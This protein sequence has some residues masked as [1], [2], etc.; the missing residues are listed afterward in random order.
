[1]TEMTAPRDTRR[2]DTERRIELAAVTTALELGFDNVTI[3]EICS[4]ADIARS[5]FFTHFHARDAAVLG[6]PLSLLSAEEA[7]RVFDAH[8]DNLPLGVHHLVV[9]SAT[10]R[11]TADDVITAR[12]RLVT[13]Q[14]EAYVYSTAMLTDS[15]TDIMTLLEG[16]LIAHPEHARLPEYPAF[17]AS[18]ASNAYYACISTIPG[19]WMASLVDPNAVDPIIRATLTDITLLLRQR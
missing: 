7:S 8:A 18:F 1:M 13:A 11:G 2:R 14:P 3:E 9:A 10:A 6:R 15:G 12:A 5:T 19:G 4:R 16:W 17:E